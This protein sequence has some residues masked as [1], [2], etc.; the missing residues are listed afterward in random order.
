[1]ISINF[2]DFVIHFPIQLGDMNLQ[3]LAFDTPTFVP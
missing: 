2:S 1:M 3:P